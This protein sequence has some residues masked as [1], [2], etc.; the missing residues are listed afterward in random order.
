MTVVLVGVIIIALLQACIE[1]LQHR[2]H[3]SIFSNLNPKFWD[4]KIS[5]LNKY[6]ANKPHLGRKKLFWKINVPVQITD[7]FHMIKTIQITVLCYILAPNIYWFIGLGITHNIVFG[8]MYHLGRKDSTKVIIDNYPILNL[9]NKR[10][11]A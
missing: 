5:W 3:N 11:R 9:F 1:V 6:I 10:I 8:I 2:F 4:P 7:A